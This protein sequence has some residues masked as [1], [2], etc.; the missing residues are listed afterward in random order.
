M[1][2]QTYKVKG[3]QTDLY[4]IVGPIVGVSGLLLG[5]AD[6]K[7]NAIAILAETYGHP[8]I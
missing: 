2:I 4:G 3:V 1:G 6:K 5:L 7:S 8:N